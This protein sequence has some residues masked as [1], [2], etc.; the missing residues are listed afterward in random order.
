VAAA[1]RRAQVAVDPVKFNKQSRES[2]K[3]N[4]NVDSRARAKK[5]GGK[6]DYYT[7]QQIFNRD[8]YDCYICGNPVDLTAP[9]IVGQPGWETYPHIEHVIPL[10]LGGDD[11]LENVRIAHAKC[12]IDKGISLL[13]TA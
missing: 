2:K 7:K 8:G 1:Y 11:T 9:H 10:A 12:N 13:A 3:R 5:H 6:Y 4:G